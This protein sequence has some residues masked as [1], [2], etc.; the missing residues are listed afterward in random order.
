M[1][2]ILE[3]LAIICFA[4]LVIAMVWLFCIAVLM[5]GGK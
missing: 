2:N 3:W 1:G 5:I 4:F